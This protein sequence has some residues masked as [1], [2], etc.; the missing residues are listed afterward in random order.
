[1]TKIPKW[2]LE[3]DKNI[4]E[5][6]S[7]I[8]KKITKSSLNDVQ[9]MLNYLN[10]KPQLGYGFELEANKIKIL[11][12]LLIENPLEKDAK[13]SIELQDALEDYGDFLTNVLSK[14]LTN[15]KLQL[16][17]PQY[18]DDEDSLILMKALKE[19]EKIAF[20]VLKKM[21]DFKSK[22][23]KNS[24]FQESLDL[25]KISE[26][27]VFS[28]NRA[29]KGNDFVREKILTYLNSKLNSKLMR[30]QKLRNV[31]L[32]TSKKTELRIPYEEAI[33]LIIE[34]FEKV[35]PKMAKMVRD[36][37]D[38]GLIE[39]KELPNKRSGACAT[40]LKDYSI[41]LLNYS[42]SLTSVITLAHELG[43]AYHHSILRELPVSQQKYPMVLAETASMIAENIVI[44]HLIEKYKDSDE[45]LQLLHKRII[46]A[47]DLTIML[48]NRFTLEES[49]EYL[50]N[51]NKF[52]LD[53]INKASRGNDILWYGESGENE[54]D[55]HWMTVRHFFMPDMPY[56]NYPYYFGYLLVELLSGLKDKDDFENQLDNFLALTG[57]YR[58]EKAIFKSFNID[59][60]SP[61]A[62][63]AAMEKVNEKLDH[64]LKILEKIN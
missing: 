53:N 37:N 3:Q 49:M 22:S 47:Y 23:N 16:S 51:N 50:Y 33:E 41:A 11:N 10:L 24:M 12:N 48:P 25:N 18:D 40:M 52:T 32:K 31:K 63:I 15:Y 61:M 55:N 46:K 8:P 44:D 45:L 5:F 62:W 54:V 29:I 60:N 42:E 1:M 19:N 35:S 58:P 38:S 20:D 28:M 43:H 17:S 6:L 4:N 59:I 27:T 7:S 39:Y 30:H 14:D 26:T 21:F 13:A 64:D 36:M 34:A 2:V 9:K 57:K 56:Y